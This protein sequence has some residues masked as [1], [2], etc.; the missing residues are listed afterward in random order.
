[1]HRFTQRKH[2]FITGQWLNCSMAS[3]LL[4]WPLRGRMLQHTNHK[5]MLFWCNK[6]IQLYRNKKKRIWDDSHGE[7]SRVY[8]GLSILC[9]KSNPCRSLLWPAGMFA[10]FTKALKKC[11][12]QV[13]WSSK[14]QSRLLTEIH[15]VI[16]SFHARMRT[17]ATAVKQSTIEVESGFE[18]RNTQIWLLFQNVICIFH[19]VQA[20]SFTLYMVMDKK[21]RRWRTGS[22]LQWIQIKEKTQERSQSVRNNVSMHACVYVFTCAPK[23][24]PTSNLLSR[25]HAEL[26]SLQSALHLLLREHAN[27]HSASKTPN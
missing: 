25:V 17:V 15:F 18:V 2:Y 16:G 12:A 26:Q 14:V 22:E 13:C 24:W 6:I 27:V 23:M 1:M 3:T 7:S 20:F 11:S 21:Q 9:Q 10:V 4:Q 19:C 5:L 8:T